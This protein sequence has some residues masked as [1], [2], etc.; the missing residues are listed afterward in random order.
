MNIIDISWPITQGMTSYKNKNIVEVEQTKVFETDN[1]RES[2]ACLGMHTGTHVDAPAHFLQDG[3][4]I[5]KIDLQTLIGPCKVLDL[6]DAPDCITAKDLQKHTIEQG[7]IILLKTQNSSLAPTDPFNPNF[8]Y[9]HKSGA[10][11]LAENNIKTVGIDYLGIER[12]Q[13]EHETHVTLM[14]QDIT[15]IEGLRL[16]KVKAGKYQLYCLPINIQ[17]LE[18]SVARA[19]LIA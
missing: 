5:D 16:Q 13:P 14:Q 1:A 19:L 2:R 6:T 17:K 8:I 11:Y 3:K 9:L 4:T 12:N 18:A 7:D 10:Q 15:I